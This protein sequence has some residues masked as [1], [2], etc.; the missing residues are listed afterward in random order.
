M[1]VSSSHES[2]VFEL[3]ER[4]FSKPL[5]KLPDVAA[6]QL[7]AAHQICT[8]LVQIRDLIQDLA[9]TPHDIGGRIR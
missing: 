2:T 6:V 1:S 7:A 9:R 3:F 8:H 4:R 5:D